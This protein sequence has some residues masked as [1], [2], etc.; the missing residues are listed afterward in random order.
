MFCTWGI[1][2]MQI[3]CWISD[4]QVWLK[5][6]NPVYAEFAEQSTYANCIQK[7]NCPPPHTSRLQLFSIDGE[8]AD[9]SSKWDTRTEPIRRSG[10]SSIEL[11]CNTQENPRNS[12]TGNPRTTTGRYRRIK[13]CFL[14]YLQSWSIYMMLAYPKPAAWILSYNLDSQTISFSQ[15]IPQ[16]LK[17]WPKC[18]R[19]FRIKKCTSLDICSLDSR[20]VA[21]R[22]IT[23]CG[24]ENMGH[25]WTRKAMSTTN[26]VITPNT[27][28]STPLATVDDPISISTCP[29]SIPI[30]SWT[31]LSSFLNMWTFKRAF[32]PWNYMSAMT[33]W[34]SNTSRYFGPRW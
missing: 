15:D 26:D 25:T 14:W 5:L 8:M 34:D 12:V 13:K 33:K 2:H 18:P 3:S 6:S 16:L 9:K 30:N 1:V 28:P 7:Q 4:K 31:S 17:N 21:F 19:F 24:G 27:S 32:T 20:V 22:M 11:P 23:M 29:N 10:S